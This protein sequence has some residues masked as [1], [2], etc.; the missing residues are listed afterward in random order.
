MA[1]AVNTGGSVFVDGPGSLWTISGSLTM[2]SS[3]N[4]STLNI[5]GGGQVTA[6]GGLSINQQSSL[7]MNVGDGSSLVMGSGTLADNGNIRFK[8]VPGLAAGTYSPITPGSWAG[9]GTTQAFGGIW[10]TTTHLFTVAAAPP[11]C[12]ELLWHLICHKPSA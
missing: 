8:A 10:N 1:W 4:T 6:S 12:R 3:N 9:N 2:G 11:V 7:A 5:S